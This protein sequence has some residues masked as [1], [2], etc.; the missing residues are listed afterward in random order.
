LP[1]E[2]TSFLCDLDSISLIASEY[3]NRETASLITS[4][5]RIIIDLGAHYGIVLHRLAFSALKA[6]QVFAIEPC[7][8]NYEVLRKNIALNNLKNVSTFNLAVGDH[9]GI[10]RMIAD[11][12]ISSQY[13]ATLEANGNEAFGFPVQCVRLSELFDILGIEQADLIKIDIEGSEAKVL[14]DALPIL[15][16]VRKLDIEVHNALDVEVIA[17]LLRSVGY[18]VVTVRAGISS[19]SHRVYATR[20]NRAATFSS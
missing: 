15:T 5:D 6:T 3:L 1:F 4:D 9:S 2:R 13:R 7:P 17:E 12:T 11:D 16:R 10:V 8:P 18:E 20:P 14:R 19:G